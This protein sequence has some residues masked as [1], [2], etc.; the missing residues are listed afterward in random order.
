MDWITMQRQLTLIFIIYLQYGR[1]NDIKQLPLSHTAGEGDRFVMSCEYT[2][3]AF[4]NLQWFKQSPGESLVLLRIQLA[5]ENVTDNRYI[6][7]L[8]KEKKSSHLSITKLEVR[9]SATYWCGFQAHGNNAKLIF[10]GGTRLIV[11]PKT[12]RDLPSVYQLKS[13]K[14]VSGLPDSVCLVTD[15]PSVEQKLILNETN[16]SSEV[17][18]DKSDTDVW[19]TSVVIWDYDNPSGTL[20]CKLHYG[21]I[22]VSPDSDTD[23][24]QNTC[25][26]LSIDESFRTNPSMNTLSLT[27]LGLRVLTI[28]AIVFNVIITLRLWSS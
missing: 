13:S 4:D 5:N 8:E 3:S 1:C 22:D 11:Q 7:Q 18:L 10:G 24:S 25:S 21:N 28:K 9:D 20:P 26:S 27:V 15:I 6:F 2:D 23:E 12:D 16:I 17:V 14:T 19:R